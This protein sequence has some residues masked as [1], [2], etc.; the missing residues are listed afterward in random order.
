MKRRENI[1]PCEKS[2]TTHKK[3]GIILRGLPRR[4]GLGCPHL[5]LNV[6][7][8]A[9]LRVAVRAIILI[10]NFVDAAIDVI[11]NLAKVSNNVTSQS[12]N[13]TRDNIQYNI[14]F[15]MVE[16]LLLPCMVWM[17]SD[18]ASAWLQ[19]WVKQSY[20]MPTLMDILT[21]AL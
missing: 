13:L 3:H 19:I 14:Q 9:A 2:S 18:A 21:F 20:E 1:L 12:Y 8:G 15:S 6:V 5:S 7:D 16:R 4:R 11:F 10:K 17:L